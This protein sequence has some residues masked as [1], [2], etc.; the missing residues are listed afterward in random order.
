MA[1]CWYCH[2][3]WAKPVSDI[4]DDA[5]AKLEALGED[6]DGLLQYGPGHIVWADENFERSH[7]EYCIKACDEADAY[8]DRTPSVEAREIVK[9]SLKALLEVPEHI[10]ACEPAKYKGHNP[11]AYPPAAGIEMVNNR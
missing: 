7:V 4:Y 1:I 5:V 6:A 2:W 9:Q 11:A 3:G 8:G 10:R